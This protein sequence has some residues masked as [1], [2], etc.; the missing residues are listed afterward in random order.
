M[1]V[2]SAR[3]RAPRARAGRVALG[4]AV[5]RLPRSA[6]LCVGAAA[7]N[8]LIWAVLVPPFQVPDEPQ[9]FAYVQYLAETGKPPP[10]TPGAVFSPEETTA[11]NAL[12]FN[13]AVQNPQGRPPWT[14]LQATSIERTLN[15]PLG[16]LSQGGLSNATNNPPLYYALSVIP[17]K[18]ASHSDLLDR[19]FAMRLLSVLLA[20]V[21]VLFVY[22]F[23]RELLPGTPW[24]WTA[25]AL[26]VAFQPLFAF[27]S[28][29]VNNDA[30]LFAASAALF[31][32]LARAFRRGLTTRRALGIGLAAGLGTV[33]KVTIV[34]LLPGIAIG[35]LVLI[36]RQSRRGAGRASA[37][38]GGAATAI[39]ALPVGAYLVLNRTSWARAA[40]T[41]N[42]LATT[43]PGQGHSVREF[44]SY[45]WQFYLPHMPWM[46]THFGYGLWDIWFKGF[47][48]VF[49]WLDYRFPS[50]AYTFAAA[51]WVPI[52]AAVALALVRSRQALRRRAPELISYIVAMLGLLVLIA[53]AGYGPRKQGILFEQARYL[54]PLL[55]LYGA[56]I[57][58][59]ARGVPRRW[60]PATAALLVVLA[61]AHGLLAQLLTVSRY[62]G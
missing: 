41:G 47:I 27:D 59:A 50:W 46:R 58:L 56:L 55:A 48:G 4:R 16:R 11:L 15:Q 34:G 35:L 53:I 17:Y 62:Y 61:M 45:L 30:A 22:L 8:V 51:L 7:L 44:L 39:A 43:A 5:G 9:H 33:S 25:G 26:A 6:W 1:A 12:E 52:L 36:V 38:A 37:I 42:Q 31:F 60:G 57:G 14:T 32:G 24:A 13:R 2:T 19:L 20:C 21:T 49:G 23:L 54:L 10:S 29:G 3:A 18:L 40:W 28:S